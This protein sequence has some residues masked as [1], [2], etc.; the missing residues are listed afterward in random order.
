MDKKMNKL[1]CMVV[2]LLSLAACTEDTEYTAGVWYRR[3]DFDGVAR[4]DAAGFTI[5]NK[6]Y[7]CGG[8]RGSNKDR[9]KDCWEYDIDND[10][11]TQCK[12]MSEEAIARN[13]ATGF[14]VGTKGYIATGYD[15]KTSSFL[16]DCWQYDP[17]TNDWKQMAD[18]PGGGRRYALSFGIGQYGYLG[19]GYDDNYQKD[20]YRFDPSVGDKGEWTLI[21][22]FGGQKRQGGQVF[23]ID[24]IAYICGGE[25][26]NSDVTDF[27]CFDP[28]NASNPWKQLRDIKDSSD[29]DY[30]DD[31][32]SIARCY[33]CAFVIDGKGYLAVG[34]A[35]G[36]SLRTNYW[37]YDPSTDLWEGEDLTSFEGSARA[38]AVCFSTGT[39]GFITTG[40]STSSSYYD[41]TW[42]LKPYEYEEK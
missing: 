12:D 4:N 39:R 35:A 41:D 27:W 28:S 11:W 19:T 29:E 25:N 10:W 5:G 26:N 36:G 31:Y 33:G 23:I 32:T 18:F 38:K 16:K 8:Y 9:L 37:I 6:G 3:S 14:A 13:A 20:F 15:A 24:D 30:D 34:Q 1:L 42:E 22:G 21:N 2:V 17:A 40:G 7:I